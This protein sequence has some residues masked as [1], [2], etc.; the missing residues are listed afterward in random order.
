MRIS[1]KTYVKYGSRN[2][3]ITTPTTTAATSYRFLL[4]TFTFYLVVVFYKDH[5]DTASR[6]PNFG[7]VAIFRKEYFK[8]H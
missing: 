2:K 8:F 5:K 6:L 1:F 7:A 4:Y 3:L